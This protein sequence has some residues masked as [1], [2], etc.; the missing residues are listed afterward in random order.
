MLFYYE[1]TQKSVA[2]FLSQ[3]FVELCTICKTYVTESV[4]I[5]KYRFVPPEIKVRLVNNHSTMGSTTF[6]LHV[7]Q[8]YYLIRD[9]SI[10]G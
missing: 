9:S 6:T 5:G 1:S 10:F 3:Y 4:I 8:D 7:Y 2:V